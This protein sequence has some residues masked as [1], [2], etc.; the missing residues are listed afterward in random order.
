MK[1]KI[2]SFAAIFL[3]VGNCHA[4][5]P[6]SDYLAVSYLKIT[7]INQSWWGFREINIPTE[8]WQDVETLYL[9][10]NELQ[11]VPGKL[12]ELSQL[13]RLYLENNHIQSLDGSVEEFGNLSSLFLH[14]NDLVSLPDAM[15]GLVNIREL[16]L[17]YNKLQS[18][19]AS[20]RNLKNRLKTLNL[21]GNPL[22]ETGEN[23]TLGWR[24]LKEIFGESVL[25]SPR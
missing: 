24:D 19:P 4:G 15:G 7:E 25:F 2:V 5:S 6:E 12:G 14:G 23:G 13:R 22:Q 3:A 9:G 11:S 16:S 21:V 18:L 17:S 8:R 20:M 1:T 10:S